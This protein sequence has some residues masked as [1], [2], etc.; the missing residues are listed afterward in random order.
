V[1]RL[2]APKEWNWT[3]VPE[4][5]WWFKKPAEDVYYYLNRWK[6]M[7]FLKFLDLGCGVGRHSI[8]FAQHGFEVEALDLS[9]KGLDTLAENAKKLDLNINMTL[10]DM[11]RL[12]Y[13]SEVFDC[14]LSYH[15]ISHT[16]SQGIKL[17]MNEMKRVLK[18]GG[19]FLITLCSKESPTF[20]SGKFPKLDENTIVKNEEPEIGVPH[21]Y[22]NIDGVRE[23]L[24]DF[25]I[26]WIRHTREIAPDGPNEGTS[27]HFFIHGRKK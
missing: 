13:D 3:N 20:Q 14:L 25:E 19:E 11:H 23:T 1:L 26:I 27:C 6:E 17:I 12:P 8:F 10:G 21:Y 24:Q 16:D 18:P 4:S 22:V 5:S 9:Q 7:G 2:V 15:V